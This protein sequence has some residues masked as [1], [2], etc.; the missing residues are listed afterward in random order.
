MFAYVLIK[1]EAGKEEYV[2]S[3]VKKIEKIQKLIEVLGPY[4]GV[5][6]AEIEDEKELE[7]VIVKKLR[8]I[9]GIKET[10]TLVAIKE[11]K[12]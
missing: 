9:E 10:I 3:K 7:E 8:T 5:A 12:S 11:H 6:L 2:F 1:I 4:D